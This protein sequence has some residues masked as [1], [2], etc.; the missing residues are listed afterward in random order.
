MIYIFG[1]KSRV[2]FRFAVSNDIFV[3]SLNLDYLGTLCQ[4]E[5]KTDEVDIE[6]RFKWKRIGHKDIF[7]NFSVYDDD[8][9]C[10]F[11]FSGVA[12]S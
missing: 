6:F 10:Y 9:K 2:F 11:F 1:P 7:N 12:C 5:M 8:E 4:E 3:F